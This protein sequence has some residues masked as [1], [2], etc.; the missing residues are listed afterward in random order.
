MDT[1]L[2][3]LFAAVA[4]WTWLAFRLGRWAERRRTRHAGT[5]EPPTTRQLLFLSH[6]ADETGTAAPPVRRRRP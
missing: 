5:H 6:L 3:I 1:D 4:A 2:L